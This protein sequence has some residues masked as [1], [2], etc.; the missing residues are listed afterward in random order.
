MCGFVGIVNKDGTPVEF[1]VLSRM[2]ETIKHRGPDEEGHL[3]D[4]PAGFFHK[5]LSVIDLATGRQPL[6]IGPLTIVYN[7]EIYNYRE[8]RESLKKA[9]HSFLTNS[10]TEVLLRMYQE[11]GPEGIKALNGMFAFLIYDREKKQIMAGRD[12]FGIKPLYLWENSRHLVFGS[13][14]KALV[15]HPAVDIA[16]NY[17]SIQEYLVFQYV[18]NDETF[19][20]GI[21]KI[22]PGHYCLI[23]LESFA[24]KTVKF[25]Q[26]DFRVDTDHTEEYFVGTLRSLLEDSVA[27][28]LRSDV[29]IGAHLSGGLDSS[30]VAI[31]ASKK[32]PRP[33]RAF[34]GAF[35][36]GAEFDETRYAREAAKACRAEMTEVFPTEEDF[37]DVLPK[38]IY[39]MDEPMAGPGLFPQY[40][41]A[42]RAA[43]EVKVVLSGHG[44]DEIF[45]GYA[46]YVIAYLE[47]ALKGA[48]SETFDEGEHIVSLQSILPNLPF[49]RRYIPTLRYFWE[50]DLF[51]P[52]DRRYFRLIDRSLGDRG[53]L[54]DDFNAGFN[55]ERIFSRFQAVF[56]HPDTLSYY[57]KMVHFDMCA[58]LPALLHVED[59]VTMACS[60]ESRVPLLDP[61]IVELITRM[62]PRMKFKGAEMKYILKRSM[63]DIL[64]PL[65]LDRKD[66]M[67][68]P[69]PLHLWTRNR[70]GAFYRD[71]LLSPTCKNRGI[72]NLPQ[73]EKLM[74]TENAYGRRLWGFLN[75]ELWFRQFIDQK[76]G[77]LS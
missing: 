56:N 27:L 35:R 37:V 77:A 66:K 76:R 4:G 63:K 16:A 45:G 15:E 65:I 57:N 7:G 11:H 2:A 33:L 34:T 67:G 52:M 71:V 44:G 55:Q 72:F 46:R 50:S 18:L 26:P 29:P 75:I 64:P 39:H 74:D 38:L 31:L 36:E 5:R 14:I 6:T 13:E 58:S 48:I 12:H 8:L 30:I 60:L 73:I 40:M 23:D 19:F 32:V 49:L 1:R 28:Q 17:D 21:Q 9:G 70:L 24:K 25:W 53:S 69:V 43:Q 41:V 22:R 59:R 10:D 3:I 51:E 68:F 54:H 61:R 47:Q 42:R 62:P 20:Q